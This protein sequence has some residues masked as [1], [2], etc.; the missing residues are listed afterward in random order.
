MLVIEGSADPN[1]VEPRFTSICGVIVSATNVFVLSV[2]RTLSKSGPKN[3]FVLVV[4]DDAA[5]A[6][7][8]ENDTAPTTTPKTSSAAIAIPEVFF[9]PFPLGNGLRFSFIPLYFSVIER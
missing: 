1:T 7:V 4:I 8:R 6:C 5:Y 2:I 3:L 9:N